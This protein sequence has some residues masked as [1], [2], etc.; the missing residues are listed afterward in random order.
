MRVSVGQHPGPQLLPSNSIRSIQHRD[1]LQ[2]E[3]CV[4]NICLEIHRPR[5]TRKRHVCVSGRLRIP[6]RFSDGSR[7]VGANLPNC[8]LSSSSLSSD[9]VTFLLAWLLR[10]PL[11]DPHAGF[12]RATEMLGSWLSLLSGNHGCS[13]TCKAFVFQTTR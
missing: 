9:C 3:I 7:G 11:W 4:T 13:L 8:P 2:V 10:F 6:H 12:R 1:A 5:W